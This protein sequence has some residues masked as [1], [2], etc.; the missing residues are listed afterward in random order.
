MEKQIINRVASSG[1]I[2]FDLSELVDSN[3]FVSLDIKDQLFHGLILK[4]K[5]F[6]AFIKAEDW[7]IYE[8]KNVAVFCSA[9]AVIPTW[10][11][12]LIANKLHGIASNFLFGTM[13]ELVSDTYRKAIYLINEA[14]F[15]DQLVVIKGCGDN[16]VPVSAYMDVTD[17]L[18][19]SVKSLMFGEPCSTVPIFKRKK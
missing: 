8:N 5:D 12:M 9:D 10:A 3:S 11:Y 15:K 7:N 6:R 14:E 17:K 1:I 19:S 16:S 13:D 18:R 4:E 2:N